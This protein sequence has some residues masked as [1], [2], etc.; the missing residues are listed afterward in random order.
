MSGKAYLSVPL[1]FLA[2]LSFFLS[3]FLDLPFVKPGSAGMSRTR[4]RERQRDGFCK[5]RFPKQSSSCFS[6]VAHVPAVRDLPRVL[7]VRPLSICASS[8]SFFSFAFSSFASLS[9]SFLSL[10]Q[11]T[12]G[13]EAEA[14]E[15]AEVEAECRN[16][17]KGPTKLG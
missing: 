9:R 10:V 14:E 7:A 12:K 13:K 11:G 5:A 4:I 3:F 17:S 6:N 15:E 16:R 8:S 1:A 2:F